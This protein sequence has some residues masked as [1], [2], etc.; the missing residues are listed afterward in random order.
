MGTIKAKIIA[1][2]GAI[3]T[4][5]GVI[6]AAIAE[7][8]LCACILAPILSVVGIVSLVMGFLSQNRAYFLVIGIILLIISFIFY[9]RKKVCRI[10]GKNKIN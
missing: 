1:L 8:G 9:K 3:T 4:F 2:L 6:G 5:F 7:F 10:H